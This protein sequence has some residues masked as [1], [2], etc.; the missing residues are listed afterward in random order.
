[1]NIAPGVED[2]QIIKLHGAGEAGER[3]GGVGDLYVIVRIKSHS[4]FTRKKEDLYLTKDIGIAEALLEKDIPIADISGEV[5]SVKIPGG[6]SL[7][8]KMKVS[9]RGMPKL[10]SSSRGD[11]YITFN[12]K[13]PKHI[14]SK[15]KKLLEDLQ[16]EF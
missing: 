12:L 9:H 7:Q 2:G 14:S 1:M 10:G 4:A 8:E 6:F 5:F 11:L 3:Q 16:S 13:L 15:A